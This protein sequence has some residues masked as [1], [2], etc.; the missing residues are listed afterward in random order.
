MLMDIVKKIGLPKLILIGVLGVFL[1]TIEIGDKNSDDKGESDTNNTFAE[2]KG[3]N[4]YA[5]ELETKIKEII[6]NIDGIDQVN[7]CISLKSSTKKVVLTE[8][9]YKI[10]RNDDNISKST[11]D[12]EKNIISEEKSYNTVYEEDKQG[13]KVPYV[14]TYNY[15]DIKGVAVGINTPLSAELKEK[16]IEIVKSLT[17]V[18]INNIAVI[19]I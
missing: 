16:I 14:V 15:P 5:E 1:I 18:S 10:T 6:G 9:P 12:N 11:V 19:G 2:E 13:N 3:V 4:E 17:G 8:T 7:V